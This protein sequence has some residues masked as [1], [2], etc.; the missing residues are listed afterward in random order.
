ME[1]LAL[2]D[3]IGFKWYGILDNQ[4]FSTKTYVGV[5]D[6]IRHIEKIFKEQA[7]HPSHPLP[8]SRSLCSYVLPIPSRRALLFS[9]NPHLHWLSPQLPPVYNLLI[10]KVIPGSL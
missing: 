1:L 9:P 8:V 6:S 2:K 5:D 10:T 3:S 4:Y 7:L